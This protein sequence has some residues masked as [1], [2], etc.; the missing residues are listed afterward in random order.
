[1]ARLDWFA[2]PKDYHMGVDR[3]VIYLQESD[4][5]YPHGSV[6]NG[7][8]AVTETPTGGEISKIYADNIHYGGFRTR[9]GF[10]GRIETYDYPDD[11]VPCIGKRIPVEGLTVNLQSRRSF[12]MAYRTL[13]N[14]ND[15]IIHLIYAVN[16]NPGEHSYKTT[17]DSADVTVHG[18][19]FITIPTSV[20]N[21]NAV[22]T[23]AIDTRKTDDNTLGYI[24]DA[25]YGTEDTD[26]RL[27]LYDE[28]IA[29]E[30]RPKLVRVVESL[31]LWEWDSFNFT[32]DTVPAVIHD[33]AERR[34][35]YRPN[36]DV[37]Q[38]RP[39]ITYSLVQDG[40]RGPHPDMN[41]YIVELIVNPTEH[42]PAI[43]AI[44]KIPNTTLDT[45]KDVGG[46]Y[47]DRTYA[48]YYRDTTSGRDQLGIVVRTAVTD[49]MMDQ[50]TANL[51]MLP[52]VCQNNVTISGSRISG[53]LYTHQ[54]HRGSPTHYLI[55]RVLVTPDNA[56]WY[57][58]RDCVYWV[59][60]GI[61]NDPVLT[62]AA[63]ELSSGTAVVKIPVTAT[64]SK[65]FIELIRQRILPKTDEI[66][67]EVV[68]R[69]EY[70]LSGLT[71]A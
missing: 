43:T 44:Q 63:L 65:L 61:N 64:S 2:T 31:R 40:P 42:A 59:E 45:I 18:L 51:G 23:V 22:S 36:E 60:C 54:Y 6:W 15:Y 5:S 48:I 56:P 25:I 1:M 8:R 53:T 38:N 11:L 50:Y 17:E 52:S 10:G 46:G 71:L 47:V 68:T 13:V 19:E 16:L 39:E 32:K 21:L 24:E 57:S 33:K 69:K 49:A 55:F 20:Q 26:P 7:L 27:P 70:S 37:I 14:A 35:L 28:V 29:F 4:G 34:V 66:V 3:G 9:E 62:R 41:H 12:G 67:T 30:I 58:E